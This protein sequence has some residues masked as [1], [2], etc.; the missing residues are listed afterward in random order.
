MDAAFYAYRETNR[1][2]ANFAWTAWL[3]FAPSPR[4]PAV[5]VEGKHET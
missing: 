5:N 4:S 2:T 1:G 3:L